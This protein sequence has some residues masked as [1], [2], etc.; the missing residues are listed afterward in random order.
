[1][2]LLPLQ[3]A[4]AA[5]ITLS[6]TASLN[7]G[8]LVQPWV[9]VSEGTAPTGGYGTDFYIRR[10]RLIVAGTVNERL[11]FFVETDQPNLGRDGR[12][13][14]AFFIQDAF[15][16]L[17]LAEGHWLD[18][19]MLLVPFTHHSMQ[20]AVSLNTLDYHVGLIRPPAGVGPSWRDAG[21]MARGFVGQL[22][23]RVGLFNGVE[24]QAPDNGP[25][26]N[27]DD[28]P[29][30]VGHVRWNI[31]GREEPFFFS[32]IYFADQPKL[33]VGVG[34]D[35]QPNAAVAAGQAH[36][37]VALGADVFLEYPLGEDREIIF[38]ANAFRYW[39]GELN[40]A[41][42]FGLFGEAGYRMG[43][44]EPVFS[45]E[46]FNARVANV[47]LFA[48]RPGLNF[49]ME[50]HVINFKAEVAFVRQGALSDAPTNV[51]GTAQ[52]QLFY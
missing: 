7:V 17:K 8:V 38:Q 35:F 32:G 51:I 22:H 19:G 29:R 39:Q 33:S 27:V 47:D 13:G 20:G 11:S 44:L 9:Q 41:S 30:A 14:P 43:R 15:L 24:G 48:L 46:Y 49:W 4:R 16:S 40:P 52:L 50:K 5:K 45:A 3:P 12:W 37:A 1:V 6:E 2:A 26:V 10:V 36:D 28:A 25:R 34:A 18:A 21:V 42:G 23:Y 31:L